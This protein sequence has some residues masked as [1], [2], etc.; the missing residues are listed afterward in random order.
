VRD[1]TTIRRR[2]RRVNKQRRVAVA[3]SAAGALFG[4]FGDALAG[5]RALLAGYNAL[6]LDNVGEDH[7]RCTDVEAEL[8][9]RVLETLGRRSR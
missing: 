7:A 4:P 6:R 2:A 1:T 8:V 3:G 9:K 5:D